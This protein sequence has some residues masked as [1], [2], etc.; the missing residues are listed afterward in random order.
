MLQFGTRTPTS[1]F[2][3]FITNQ[4]LDAK[5]KSFTWNR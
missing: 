5:K 4:A 1:E 2:L 3:D